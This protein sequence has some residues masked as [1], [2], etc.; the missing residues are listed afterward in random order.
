[1]RV[2]TRVELLGRFAVLVD[3]EPI[4]DSQWRL[5]KSRSVIKLLALA[6]GRALHPE[7]IQEL[8]WPQ[9]EPASASN[10]LRQAVYHA[11]RALG[12]GGA[13]GAELIAM[14]GDL[15]ALAP[16]VELD[17]DAFETAAARAE[18]SREPADLEQ[19][20]AAYSGELLPE[21]AYEDW[22]AERRRSLGERH[23]HLLLALAA[24]REPGDAVD[25]L[26]RTIVADPLNEE[27]HRALMRAYAGTGRRSQALAQYE[28]LRRTLEDALAADPEPVTRELY[29]ELLAEG[30]PA[31]ATAAPATAPRGRHNL[32]WQPTSFVGRRRELE[33][34]EHVLD[35]RRLVTLTGPGGCGKTRLAY[36]LAVRR[37]DRYPDGAWAIELAGIGDPGL[38]GQ[39]AA[40]ALGIDLDARDEPES[41]LARHLA[42]RE[43]LLVLD[44][45]EHLLS[46]CARLAET[47]LRECPGVVVLATSRE[48]LH[49]AGEVD[50]RV[51]SLSLTEVGDAADVEELAAADAVQLFCDRAVA[52][53]PRFALTKAN[54][55][56]V[57]EICF[58]LDGLPLA[59]EL[60][61]AR[62]T[63]LSPAQIVERLHEGLGVLRTT[64]AGGLTRQQTLQGTLD[65]SHD[66]LGESERVLFRRLAVFARGF[67][68][69]AAEAICEGG[70][71]LEGEI[72]D[73]LTG[74]VEK[75]LVAVDDSEEFYRY[76]LLE[77]VRQYAAER[78]HEAAEFAAF[79]ERHARWF[80][81]VTDNPGSR[82]WDAEPHAV[83]RLNADHDNLRAALA[84]ML[85]HEPERAQRMAAGMAG[86]WLLRGFLREGCNWLDRVIAN[87]TEPTLARSDALL[88]RQALERRRHESYDFADQLCEERVAIH[89]LRGDVRG[90]C[91][92]LLDLADGYLLRG[93]FAAAADLPLRVGELAAELGEPGLLAAARE[94]TGIAAAWRGDLEP[95]W[96]AFDEAM[97]LCEGAP[98]D[99][100]PSSAVVSLTCFLANAVSPSDYPVIRFEETGLNFR[101][102]APS[103]ARAS[104]L[105]HRAYLHRSLG[106]F[107]DARVALD[108]ALHLAEAD[109]AELD[110]ARL[111]AQ[112]GALEA[113]AGDLDAAELWLERSLTERRR[114]REH[115]GILLT[116]ANLAVVAG[117]RGD[118]VRADALLA[119]AKRMADEAVDGPGT[120]AVLLAHAE[121]A[122][123]AG[124][125]D[126]A[127]AAIDAAIETI[128]GRQD[129]IHQVAWLRVQQ[130]YLSLELTDA[131]AAERQ[132]VDAS[133]RFSECDMPLGLRYCDAIE[134]R[135]RAVNTALH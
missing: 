118:A 25:L 63:T 18:A 68:F 28:A 19:A 45:C 50:W 1:M 29:R 98:L 105:S 15:L 58:R 38:V 36:E 90:E 92:A 99:A 103:T 41:A 39:A 74:L 129:L 73:V 66:L 106:Q 34:L 125:P 94:R 44:N 70:G 114:L 102:L 113:T 14:S 112:R 23:V 120:G 123:I 88:A 89:H 52:A 119:Q 116:L 128:Y 131:A 21:D 13:D 30:A 8:L 27:A 53:S 65:W 49:L 11:R 93:R 126:A 56:A 35:S 16:D 12:C 124:R 108:A 95:A 7:R 54:A 62:I 40:H 22:V 32:P 9:R 60:A 83:D 109:G 3:G 121:I 51:P 85:N 20:I 87:A 4:P 57:A 69:E 78:L 122:R 81:A 64:R 135:L 33:Q 31:P 91:L 75:S 86:L 134:E 17:V 110:S 46:A 84:W 104:L 132:V 37:A 111:A 24:A 26:H 48:P 59:I 43:T 2:R 77:P 76:R 115:R 100:A 55:S 80:A 6:P 96:R 79:G 67:E 10:N 42:E 117:T 71:L 130:A 5:R 72:L 47:L 127:R 61:A 97:A 101:R 82:V 107:G 133:A